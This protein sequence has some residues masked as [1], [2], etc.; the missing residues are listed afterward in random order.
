MFRTQLRAVPALALV[1]LVSCRHVEVKPP[2]TTSVGK[3]VTTLQK[4]F[5]VAGCGA[6]TGPSDPQAWWDGLPPENHR[7]PFAGWETSRGVSQ[8]CLQTRVDVYRAAF[9]FNLA[10]VAALKGLVQRAELVVSTRALP[11]AARPGGVVT[12]GPFGDPSSVTL[13]CPQK[14][15]GAGSLVRFGPAAPVPVTAGTGSLQL[16]GSDPLP[17]G[18]STV[19][20]LPPS[21][22]VGPIAGATSPTTVAP[23]GLGG[24]TIVTDVTGQVTAALNA[25]MPGL[26]WMLTS[27]FEGELPGQLPVQGVLD[28]RTSY[29]VDLRVTHY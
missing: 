5:G 16:L 3:S 29:A 10:S 11:P 26:S 2:Q 21:F 4:T 8:G 25:D 24:A 20:T 15:G 9:T 14:V 28:C 19:Y 1:A 7:Y 22:T 12:A 27:N 23:D 18:T 6:S 17:G 13:F